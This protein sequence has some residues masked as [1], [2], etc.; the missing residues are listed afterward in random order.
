MKV[1]C[2]R[3][4]ET[5]PTCFTLVAFFLRMRGNVGVE[6][7]SGFEQ[8]VAKCAPKSKLGMFHFKMCGKGRFSQKC[9]P[10]TDNR[11]GVSGSFFL[12]GMNAA[13]VYLEMLFSTKL[14][15]ANFANLF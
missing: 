11:A 2:T 6:A 7:V 4:C 15:R 1:Q 8:L 14:A 12:P 5:P 9:F 3:L 10:T 13:H